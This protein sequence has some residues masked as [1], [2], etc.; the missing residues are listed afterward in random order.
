[1]FL[2]MIKI[3]LAFASSFAI[4]S[5]VFFAMNPHENFKA[6]MQSNVGSSID[7]SRTWAGPH[8][9][10]IKSKELKNGNTE[11]E[12]EFRGT[13][14]YFFEFNPETRIIEKWRFEGSEKDCAIVP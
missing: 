3:I 2:K 10:P 12:Y 6:H 11:N 14:H 7:N 8:F 4:A 1:M 9:K 13:C 5:C